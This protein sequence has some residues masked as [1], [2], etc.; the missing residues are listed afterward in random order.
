M[1]ILPLKGRFEG[2]TYEVKGNDIQVVTLN[3]ENEETKI[4]A[5]AGSLFYM[6]SSVKF[7]AGTGVRKGVFSTVKSMI[8]RKMAGESAFVL[9][10]SGKG[11]VSF[12]SN[13]ISRIIPVRLDNE[14]IF[15]QKDSFLCG[16]GD[17]DISFFVEKSFMRGIFGGEGFVF[18]KISGTGVVFISATGFV[19]EIKLEGN[20]ILVETGKAV[21]W[22]GSVNYS[23]SMIKSLKTAI[24]GGE[25]LFLTCFSGYGTI[26]VQ[27]ISFEALR[28]EIL[29]DFK[30][31]K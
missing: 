22:D 17:L 26:I 23:V 7:T 11:K 24:F 31:E 13:R 3:L 1:K 5:E 30:P 16:E 6:D 19:E 27:S 10:F 18:Q 8:K 29:R 2:F 4:F 15:A 14:S 9:E 28:E 21:A 25:G 20:T 12:T